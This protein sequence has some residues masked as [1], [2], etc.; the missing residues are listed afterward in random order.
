[1]E[2]SISKE[3]NKNYLAKVVRLDNL[4]KHSNADKLQ[5]A[6]IDF[7]N[8]ITSL[9]AKEGD[10]YIYFP[11]ESAINQEFLSWSNSFRDGELNANKEKNAGFFEKNCRV[12]AVNLRGEKSMGYIVPTKSVEAFFN[13]SINLAE[14]VGEEFDS[15][16]DTV[17]VKKYLVRQRVQNPARQGKKPRISR[18]IDGQVRLHVDTENLRKNA[19]KIKQDTDISIT[20]KLHGTSFWVSHAP[21]KR[22][23]SLTEKVLRK[24]GVKID[25]VEYDHVYGSRRVVKNEYETQETND[26]YG[27]DLWENIKDDIKDYV[28]K[29]YTFYGE[30]VGFTKEGGAIQTAYDYG[31][32]PGQYKLYIYR[33]TYT[34]ADG[35][36]RNLKT[37]EMQELAKQ[38]FLTDGKIQLVPVF[39]IGKAK[40]WEKRI[41]ASDD[42][43]FTAKLIKSLEKRYNDKECYMC[44]NTVPEEGVVVRVERANEFEAYKLKSFSF[45]EHETKMLD[46]G[47]E[48]MEEQY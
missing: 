34:N 27:G 43:E 6:V 19:Y 42:R 8:V 40:D 25:E 38:L 46:K 29:N 30:C 24:L 18:L 44:E 31:C 16:G 11:V 3:A 26:Y 32:E 28:P 4:Q 5:I 12:K 13:H 37:E 21:V 47:E 1:M 41:K 9:E 36:V 7:Q 23:L 20:Y 10:L 35:L 2:I 33:I 15:I 48:D 22:K 17:L 14:H 39:Y 45:L